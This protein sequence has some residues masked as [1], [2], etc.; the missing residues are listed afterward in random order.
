MIDSQIIFD[1]GRT[2][3]VGFGTTGDSLT[4]TVDLRRAGENNISPWV[5]L[6]EMS[7]SVRNTKTTATGQSSSGIGT[8][9]IIFNTDTDTPEI[10]LP[11]D[12]NQRTTYWCGI[13]TTTTTDTNTTYDS[14]SYTHLT[15]PT[16]YSV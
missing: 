1:F 11:T 7:T 9:A 12:G 4:G 13:S 16:I 10:Y 5:F 15:L 2:S 6:P 8:G 3:Q 14:V